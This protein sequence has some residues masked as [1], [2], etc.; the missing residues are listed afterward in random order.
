MIAQKYFSCIFCN[1]Y[2][3]NNNHWFGKT[4]AEDKVCKK[5]FLITDSEFSVLFA[6]AYSFLCKKIIK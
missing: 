3:C 5:G 1:I 6:C 4:I 2:A